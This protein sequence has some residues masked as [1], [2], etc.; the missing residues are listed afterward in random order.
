MGGPQR[1]CPIAR[2]TA[3]IACRVC[4]AGSR[5]GRPRHVGRPISRPIAEV[6]RPTRTLDFPRPSLEQARRKISADTCRVSFR[7]WTRCSFQAATLAFSRAEPGRSFRARTA[8]EARRPMVAFNYIR[9]PPD[10]LS[11][12]PRVSACFSQ[13]STAHGALF[14][15]ARY[16]HPERDA[17]KLAS[18]GKQLWRFRNGAPKHC[19]CHRLGST[20]R[21]VGPQ[22]EAASLLRNDL[23]PTGDGSRAV[24]ALN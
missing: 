4:Q 10:S 6:S 22:R 8:G 18:V 1:R 21:A 19:G 17:S 5:S 9:V 13:T 16:F 24:L 20:D 7:I 14:G 15:R 12:H 11:F 23:M 2:P 3:C